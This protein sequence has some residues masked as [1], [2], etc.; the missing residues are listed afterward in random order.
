M[1]KVL[2]MVLT[3]STIEKL[4]RLKFFVVREFGYFPTYDQLVNAI[5]D[6]IDMAKTEELLLIYKEANNN[7]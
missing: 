7:E 5:F 3:P 2:T 4:D 1:A 6:S